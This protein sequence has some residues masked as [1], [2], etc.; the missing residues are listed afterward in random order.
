MD[1]KIS[2]R[3]TL[4]LVVFES[5]RLFRQNRVKSG[6]TLTLV[7]F[8]CGADVVLTVKGMEFNL[9]IGCI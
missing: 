7:V 1:T 2:A 8:E 3:L 5:K 6:L 4:T 9:N